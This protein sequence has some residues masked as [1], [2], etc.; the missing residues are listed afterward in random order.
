MES[1]LAR[2]KDPVKQ[3]KELKTRPESYWIRRG[4]R[5]ALNLFHRMSVRVPAYKDFLRKHK[6]RPSSI[7]TIEDFK[8]IPS[9]DKDN[10]LRKYTLPKLCWDGK[11]KE[12]QWT[13]STTSGSTGEPF[14]FPREDSQVLEYAAL[15]EMYLRDNFNIHR[16]STLYINAFPMG[17]WIGGVFTY[18]AIKLI[19]KRGKYQMSTIAS[20]VHK[21]EV[22]NAVKSLSPYFDQT[23]I[24]CYGPFLKDILDDGEREGVQWRKYDIGLIF[25]A[26]MFTEGFRDYV[27]KKAGIK[28]PY[29]RTLNMY[30]TVDLGT[31]A[32][33]TPIAILARRQALKN[34]SIYQNLFG[35]IIKLPTFVQYVP[36]LF[37][38]EDVDGRVFCS[39]FSG[40]PLI[41]Y[42][43]KDQG[44]I[45]S[46]KDVLS[47]FAHDGVNLPSLS[48]QAGIG[49]TVW[50]LPFAY[51]Y[52]RSDFSVS[53]FAFQIYP[54]TIRRALLDKR[55]QA[56]MT[57]KFVM[58][59]TYTSGQNQKLT[60]HVEMKK[61]IKNSVTLQNKI[62]IV[63]IERLLKEN[64]EY[65]ETYKQ[66]EAKI[67]PRIVLWEY[68]HPKYF[69][70]GAKQQ[71][72]KK[73]K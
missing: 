69:K 73:Q 32:H 24:G 18:E 44:G 63:A 12:G 33:E 71:W 66:K 64:S 10:Y 70:S 6:I 16:K 1:Q 21:Q 56:S 14:Y 47:I 48:K 41:R 27:V 34:T 23:I 9:L 3:L 43:L 25:A 35:N 39:T 15:A 36:E 62:K 7:Q 60:L 4:E 65:R 8:K 59:V 49:N 31:M 38:F 67:E 50:K 61:G 5:M 29:L 68:E 55:L 52:E 54:E 72:V 58:M 30:G 17:A 46:Y 57:G 28:N 2:W 40:L 37:Y 51:V 11:L 53:L 26:E 42:D 22:I 45:I 13:I 19:A 20:G